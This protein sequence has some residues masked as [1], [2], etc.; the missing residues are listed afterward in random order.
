MTWALSG[1]ECATLP[2]QAPL[3]RR[4]ANRH[5]LACL[6]IC[7]RARAEFLGISQ[8][9][10]VRLISLQKNDGVEQLR[11]LPPKMNVETLGDDYDAD[12]DDAFLNTAAVMETLDLI[13]GCDTSVTQRGFGYERDAE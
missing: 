6:A 12:D 1:P 4:P 11:D 5:S 2:P 9:P 7:E 3:A 13:I 8:I 10:N